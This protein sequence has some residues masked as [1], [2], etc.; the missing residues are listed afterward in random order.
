MY[1]VIITSIF[2][3]RPSFML[4]DCITLMKLYENKH[5]PFM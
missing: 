2:T 3:M 5:E 4:H 1:V